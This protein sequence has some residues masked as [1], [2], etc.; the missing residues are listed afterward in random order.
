MSPFVANSIGS[1]LLNSIFNNIHSGL[2]I[3]GLDGKWVV[4][5]KSLSQI[6]GYSQEEFLKLSFQDITH[7]DDLHS[8]LKNVSSLLNGDIENYQMQK[9]YFAKAGNIVWA[10]LMV[11]LVKDNL[12][13]PQYF[14]SQIHD[15]TKQKEETQIRKNLNTVVKAQNDRLMNFSRIISHNLRTHTGNLTTL[16]SFV[17]DELARI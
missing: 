6:L 3:V 2:A 4:V 1:D 7:K 8:D 12:G 9:R 16:T 13:K 11:S 5:S 17:E 14:I 15:I 10:Q